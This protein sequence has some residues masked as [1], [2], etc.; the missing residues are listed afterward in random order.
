[1]IDTVVPNPPNVQAWS[2]RM[3][4][5]CRILTQIPLIAWAINSSGVARPVFAP[6]AIASIPDSEGIAFAT[7]GDDEWGPSEAAIE[8]ALKPNPKPQI[9]LA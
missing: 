9:R 5:G 8:L 3:E 1:M 6:G 7:P 4:N 2:I